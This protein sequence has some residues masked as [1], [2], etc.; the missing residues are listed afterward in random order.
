MESKKMTV[1]HP[2]NWLAQAPFK[3]VAVFT[4]PTPGDNVDAYNN[5]KREYIETVRALG[6]SGGSCDVCGNCLLNNFVLEGV[7]GKRFVVGCDCVAKMGQ[8]E[9]VTQVEMAKRKH[10]RKLRRAR[11]DAKHAAR[12]AQYELTLQAE[13]ERNGGMTDYEMQEAA[14]RDAARAKEQAAGQQNG[15]LIDALIAGGSTSEF[16]RAMIDK[17][18]TQ[19]LDSHNFSDRMLE[20][21]G[22]IYAKG[23]RG[24][25]RQER[26]NEFFAIV[27]DNDL[28]I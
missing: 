25:E 11:S 2:W 14:R 8:G 17:L 13:R 27:R 22:D 4:I 12:M 24:K 23:A 18:R 1:D 19:S 5:A 10:E 26:R 3:L 7:D 16:V 28:R 15:W 21:L 20:I 6:V 9:V